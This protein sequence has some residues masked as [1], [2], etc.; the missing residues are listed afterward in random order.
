MTK[1]L[2]L[3]VAL[4]ATPSA[5]TG[6]GSSSTETESS[7]SAI[8][9]AL[10]TS[11]LDHATAVQCFSD[12]KS[13]PR[14]SSDQASVDACKATLETCLPSGTDLNGALTDLCTPPSTSPPRF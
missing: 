13:C 8:S 2:W 9:A 7:T 4:A 5:C 6:S 11:T 1:H 10:S 3:I 12:F 14:T